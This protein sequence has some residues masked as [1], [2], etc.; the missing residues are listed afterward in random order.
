MQEVKVQLCR[1]GKTGRWVSGI[2]TIQRF[3]AVWQSQGPMLLLP[4]FLLCQ[5]SN[6]R[7]FTHW[8]HS[9]ITNKQNLG[10]LHTEGNVRDCSINQYS[11]P[12]YTS[13]SKYLFAGEGQASPL[14]QTSAFRPLNKIGFTVQKKKVSNCIPHVMEDPWL[15]VNT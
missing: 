12:Q 7:P 9:N 5:K 3:D 14:V 10:S 4:G 2:L 15:F 8:L 13:G 1:P 6:L 11:S